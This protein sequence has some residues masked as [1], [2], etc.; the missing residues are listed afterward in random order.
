MVTWK[1]DLFHGNVL[2][3]SSY[4]RWA[5]DYVEGFISDVVIL[6]ELFYSSRTSK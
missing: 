2:R 5:N 3:F 1:G 6:V 4:W